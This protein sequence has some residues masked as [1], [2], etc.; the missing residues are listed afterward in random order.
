MDNFK[1]GDRVKSDIDRRFNVN[2]GTVI[3]IRNDRVIGVQ[4]DNFVSGHD[5]D[6]NGL[7]GYCYYFLSKQILH[8]EKNNITPLR[9]R[10][11]SKGNFSDWEDHNNE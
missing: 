6:G 2:I 8:V 3:E 10:W 9:I 5:C 7:D 4:F 1:I 11:Y